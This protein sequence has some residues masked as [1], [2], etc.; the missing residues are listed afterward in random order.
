MGRRRQPSPGRDCGTYWHGG[1][2]G[3]LR[4]LTNTP[5]IVSVAVLPSRVTVRWRNDATTG[6]RRRLLLLRHLGLLLHHG[7]GWVVKCC[8]HPLL[9]HRRCM[10]IRG[11][12]PTAHVGS[13]WRRW[14]SH[15]SLVLILLCLLLRLLVSASGGSSSSSNASGCLFALHQ[16]QGQST[17]HPFILPVAVAFFWVFL[18]PAQRARVLSLLHHHLVTTLFYLSPREAAVGPLHQRS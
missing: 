5:S 16:S 14:G 12:M 6:E 9:Q 13:V 18:Q 3:V 2:L 10:L 1:W 11:G 8:P 15:W 4:K 17:Q 7:R